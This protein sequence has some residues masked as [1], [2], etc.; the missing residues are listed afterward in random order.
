MTQSNKKDYRFDFS[1]VLT[2][3]EKPFLLA[4]Y[5]PQMC[6][7]KTFDCK[8]LDIFFIASVSVR[9]KSGMQHWN[10]GEILEKNK[11]LEDKNGEGIKKNRR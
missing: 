1:T 11:T 3:E 10:T 5:N 4:F 6:I 7:R 8:D 2:L 9:T